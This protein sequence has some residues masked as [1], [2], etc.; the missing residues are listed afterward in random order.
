MTWR[1]MK[2]LKLTIAYDG[3]GYSGW[4]VQPNGVTI[5]ELL[6]NSVRKMTNE[7]NNVVGSGRTD[8]GVHALAQV[9]VFRTEKD[10]PL[11]G[12]LKGINSDL[13]KDI[14]VLN[15]EEVSLDF[16]PIRDSKKKSYRYIISDE[17][18]EHPLLLNRKWAVGRSLDLELMNE[19]ARHLVGEHDFSAFKA[20]DGVEKGS[21]RRI[22]KISVKELDCFGLWP[23]ND[24]NLPVIA[25]GAKQSSSRSIVIDIIGNGF[26]KNM[27]RNIVG[28]LVDVGLK[29][30][31]PNQ[32]KDILDSRDRKRAGVCAPAHGLYLYSVE[33]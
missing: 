17:D 4:Q 8:A 28:T 29:K 1:V 21:V 3:T 12:F 16:H 22:F 23:R 33:Y 31:T 6:Q 18:A 32:F 30:I 11:D 5:Q 9:A 7:E 26:L 10:I 13:P 20:A 15:I 19:A 25:S 27:V 24:T 14:R 2:N